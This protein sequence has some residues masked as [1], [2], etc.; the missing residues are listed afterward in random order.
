[1]IELS[2]NDAVKRYPFLRRVFS[3]DIFNE[4][5]VVRVSEDGRTFSIVNTDSEQLRTESGALASSA[6]P[7]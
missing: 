7:M 4:S 6:R 3:R 5:Y 2:Y 1:M